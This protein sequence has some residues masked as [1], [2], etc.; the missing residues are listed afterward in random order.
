MKHNRLRL[1]QTHQSLKLCRRERPA[2]KITL[3]LFATVPGK[4]VILI[5]RFNT[6]GNKHFAEMWHMP[7]QLLDTKDDKKLLEYAAA[8]LKDPEAFYR[9]V[10]DL[11][12][13]RHEKSHEELYFSDGRVWDRYSTPLVG[14]NG[15]YYGRIWYFRDIT[16]RR[17]AEK[18]LEDY[19]TN[20]EAM[21]RQKT[22]E[23]EESEIRFKTLFKDSRDGI[24]LADA[25]RHACDVNN[26][27]RHFAAIHRE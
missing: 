21:V 18:A 14:A 6:F 20:L 7:Q 2:E 11:Y 9:Q 1:L 23:I 26:G 3:H 4:E 15:K 16:E 19:R 8:Q 22:A 17:K 27:I 24:L 13:R 12:E 5:L 10:E 25:S